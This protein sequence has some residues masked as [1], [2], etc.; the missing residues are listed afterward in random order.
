[1]RDARDA[2]EYGQVRGGQ[3][4]STKAPRRLEVLGISFLRVADREREV[5][6]LLELLAPVADVPELAD[7]KPISRLVRL[8]LNPRSQSVAE[9]RRV[10]EQLVEFADKNAI[11]L[12]FVRLG[13]RLDDEQAAEP[14]DP[15][16]SSAAEAAG[17]ADS[18]S[19]AAL[20]RAA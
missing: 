20:R 15:S 6:R 2:L 3:H 19:A 5:G 16:P 4:V 12:E 8:A 14:A 7:S 11:D 1:M 10:A 9:F 13:V 17:P 18:Y